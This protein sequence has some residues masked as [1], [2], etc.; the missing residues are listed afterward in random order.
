MKENN[1]EGYFLSIDFEKAFDS[2]EWDFLWAVLEAFGF[3]PEFIIKIKTMYQDIEACIINGGSSTKYFSFSRCIKQGCPVSGLLFIL[4]IELLA[5]RMRHQHDIQGIVVRDTEIKVSAFADDL[6]NFLRNIQSIRLTLKELEI[7]G[8]VSGLNCNISKCEALALGSSRPEPIEYNGQEIKW[9][10]EITVIGIIFSNNTEQCRQKN[11]DNVIEKLQDQLNIWKQRDLSILGKVQIIKT[12][13]VSQLQYV[14]NMVTPSPKMLNTITKI[15]NNFLWGSNTSKVKHSACISEYNTG[16]LK[17]PDVTTILH[18]QRIMWLKRFFCTPSSQWK[19]FF[20]WQLDKVGGTSIFQ[21]PHI[22]L[23]EVEKQGLHSFYESIIVA[24]S[25]FYTTEDQDAP[26]EK[27][28]A[29]PMFLNYHI[30]TPRGDNLFYPNLISKGMLFIKDITHSGAIM[31]PEQAKN[32]FCLTG[33]ETFQYI[34]LIKCIQANPTL[35]NCIANAGINCILPDTKASLACENSK[36]VYRK[37]ITKICEKPTSETKLNTLYGINSDELKDIYKLPFMVTIETKMRSFQFKFSHLIF[38]SNDVL[39]K[40]SMIDSP[41]CTFCSNE[42][43]TL[44]HLFI[45]CPFIQPLWAALEHILNH[46]FTMQEKLFGCYKNLDDKEYDIISHSSILL[47]YYVHISRLDNRTP[48]TFIL[49]KRLI[50]SSIL[51]ETIALKK[52]KSDRHHQ[53]WRCITSLDP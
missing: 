53:K 22:A 43:E 19:V 15:L 33:N 16:G 34:S 18:T 36:T 49:K 41:L 30:S 28:L 6:N 50:Y 42:E 5:I 20:E 3:P 39:F 47:K 35:I 24:W 2:L 9:V 31:P 14:M 52:G 8:R 1:L 11:F 37:L 44:E 40:R 51:E 4:A 21:N 7:F 23:K 12:F 27:P 13:G 25:Y 17:M 26:F 48:Q 32:Q 38:W 46:K 29:L 10:D 45:N